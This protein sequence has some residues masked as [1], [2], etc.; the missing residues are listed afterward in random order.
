MFYGNERDKY[1]GE[2]F[3]W[4]MVDACLP[5]DRIDGRCLT[6]DGFSWIVENIPDLKLRE[7]FRLYAGVLGL[8]MVHN[9]IL[10]SIQIQRYEEPDTYIYAC[11][12]THFQC[13]FKKEYRSGK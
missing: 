9:L 8:K 4:L 6:V 11:C 12:S 5:A 1:N 2:Y 7:S 3:H 13:L 10:I